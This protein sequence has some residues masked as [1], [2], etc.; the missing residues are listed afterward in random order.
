MNDTGTKRSVIEMIRCRF[1][2]DH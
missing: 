1:Y 2:G